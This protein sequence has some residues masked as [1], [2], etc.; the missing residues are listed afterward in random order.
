MALLTHAVVGVVAASYFPDKPFIAFVAAFVS[1]FLIDAIPH[2]DYPIRSD[3][4]NPKVGSKFIFD[5]ALF[6]D[7]VTISA[8]ALLGLA[9]AWILFSQT[10]SLL[11]ILIGVFGGIFPDPL[12]FAYTRFR[13]EPLLTIQRF[14]EW[15]H[16]PSAI[17]KNRPLIGIVTQLF[18]LI[19]V[20]AIA[21]N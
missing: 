18:F 16:E 10:Q 6:L 2:W 12:Q 1:H 4:I 5:K 11:T 9:L 13:H 7:A 14:H 17:L 15:I 21:T 20:V 8:D 19:G 3:S